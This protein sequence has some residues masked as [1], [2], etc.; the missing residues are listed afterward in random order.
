MPK[1]DFCEDAELCQSNNLSKNANAGKFQK[2]S[3]NCEKLLKNPKNLS[4]MLESFK[5]LSK[6]G[7]IVQKSCQ[8]MRK[9]PKSSRYLSIMRKISKMS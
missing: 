9:M 4:K 3:I 6:N 1:I 5:N 8:I 2:L 7:K